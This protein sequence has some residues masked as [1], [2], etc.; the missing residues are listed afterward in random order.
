MPMGWLKPFSGHPIYRSVMCR[1]VSSNKSS[2]CSAHTD[3]REEGKE[4]R[5]ERIYRLSQS[6]P[7]LPSLLTDFLTDQFGESFSLSANGSLTLAFNHY[8]GEIFRAG[9][10]DDQTAF[11]V[12]L[13]FEIGNCLFDCRDGLDW[14]FT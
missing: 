8:A 4:W 5:E 14:W 1:R 9:V 13:I 11:S 2:N 7:S 10:A 3:S 6:L 12:H